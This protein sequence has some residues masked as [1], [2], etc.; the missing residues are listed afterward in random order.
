MALDEVP[1]LVGRVVPHE[2]FVAE[3]ELLLDQVS[4]TGPAARVAVTRDL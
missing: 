1:D 2:R 4:L 3:L